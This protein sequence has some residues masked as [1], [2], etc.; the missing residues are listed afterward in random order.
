[1]LPGRYCLPVSIRPDKGRRWPQEHV[2]TKP[3]VQHNNLNNL[4]QKIHHYL[5]LS[6]DKGRKE[7]GWLSECGGDS[8]FFPAFLAVDFF[9]NNIFFDGKKTW[10]RSCGTSSVS[11]RQSDA[12]GWRHC[13]P[14]SHK[15]SAVERPSVDVH[16]SLL[17]T[18]DALLT[19]PPHPPLPTCNR[20]PLRPILFR[21]EKKK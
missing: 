14:D 21:G 11:L 4:G 18:E 20:T 13:V 17:K 19:P 12:Q 6:T 2:S 3:Y 5:S 16:A 10:T 8:L 7:V 15:A 9:F 1:M